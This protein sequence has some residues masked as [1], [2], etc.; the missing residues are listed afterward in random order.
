MAC[1]VENH[2]KG[3]VTQVMV[4]LHF[5]HHIVHIVHIVRQ[6][7]QHWD[8]YLRQGTGAML[9]FVDALYCIQH[10]QCVAS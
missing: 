3:K 6:H 5:D 9:N 10:I 4:S 7:Q 8:C 1:E 2:E